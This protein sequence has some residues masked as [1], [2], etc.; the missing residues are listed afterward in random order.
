MTQVRGIIF[1]VD[2]TLVDSNDA[3][4]HAWVEAMEEQGYHVSFETVRPLIGMGGDKVT[5]GFIAY[6]VDTE[7]RAKHAKDHARNDKHECAFPGSGRNGVRHSAGVQLLNQV[8]IGYS[9]AAS[10]PLFRCFP[11]GLGVGNPHTCAFHVVLACRAHSCLSDQ[12]RTPSV[13]SISN[14]S[15]N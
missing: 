15:L 10:L 12:E 4:A 3:H 13:S 9:L 14:A 7:E 6:T 8:A 5:Q 11:N 1:D 2:G